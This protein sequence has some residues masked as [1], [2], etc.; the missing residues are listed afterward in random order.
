MQSEFIPI[1]YQ[2]KWLVVPLATI[3][4]IKTDD[5]ICYVCTVNKVYIVTTSLQKWTDRLPPTRFA[6]LHRSYLVAWDFITSFTADTVFIDNEEIPVAR[7][8][9]EELKNRFPDRFY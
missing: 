9:R 5:K 6:R 7:N 8:F 1:R 3:K 4:Y 2:D